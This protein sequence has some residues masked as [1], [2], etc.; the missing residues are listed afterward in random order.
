MTAAVPRAAESALATGAPPGAASSV[1][2]PTATSAVSAPASPKPA[3][4]AGAP[5]GDADDEPIRLGSDDLVVRASGVTLVRLE[6]KPRFWWLGP[7]PSIEDFARLPPPFRLAPATGTARALY[8]EQIRLLELRV[9]SNGRVEQIETVHRSVRGEWH[10]FHGDT[11]ERVVAGQEFAATDAQRRDETLGPWPCAS[12]QNEISCASPD[13][14]TLRYVF[15]AAPGMAGAALLALASAAPNVRLKSLRWTPPAFDAETLERIAAVRR[16]P[17][18]QILPPMP[19]GTKP[20][21]P[22]QG[23]IVD[24]VGA[25]AHT[26]QVGGVT[27]ILPTACMK[28]ATHACLLVVG[29]GCPA[30]RYDCEGMYLR[31]SVDMSTAPPSL[32][33]AYSNFDTVVTTQAEIEAQIAI[34]P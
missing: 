25:V 19:P 18:R 29:E 7:T 30:N 12:A 31:V 22:L 28:V 1:A 14:P 5:A 13:G 34:A 9:A 17:A 26:N 27:A 23:S 10:I 15:P 8:R 11:A 2:L 6:P 32:D 4:D 21:V 20:E 3:A 16:A 24:Y 33:A